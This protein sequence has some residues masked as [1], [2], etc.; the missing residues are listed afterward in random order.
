MVY[1]SIFKLN[2]QRF[3]W[4]HP[5]V[6]FLFC[7]Q[8]LFLFVSHCVVRR[9]GNCPPAVRTFAKKHRL[10]YDDLRANDIR[11]NF[12]KFLIDQRGVPLIHYSEMYHPDRIADDIR[13]LLAAADSN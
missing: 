5:L 12:E 11:W 2:T 7:V 6:S 10:D 3:V 8:A 1:A 13:D 9:Q 4:L